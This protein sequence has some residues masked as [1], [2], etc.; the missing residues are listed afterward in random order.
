[1][2]AI[3]ELLL[4]MEDSCMMQMKFM[5]LHGEAWDYCCSTDT[6]KNTCVNFRKVVKFHY[7]GSETEKRQQMILTLP[8]QGRVLRIHDDLMMPP[9][10]RRIDPPPPAATVVE[11]ETED[12]PPRKRG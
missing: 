5:Q 3:P 11:E 8:G 10:P 7:E 2:A 12:S 6:V 1:M 4:L 9:V